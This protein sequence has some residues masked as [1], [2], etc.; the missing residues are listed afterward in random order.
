MQQAVTQHDGKT[1][2][3][4]GLNLQRDELQLTGGT[5]GGR[6]MRRFPTGISESA[7]VFL[8]WVDPLTIGIWPL[9]HG[10]KTA[11]SDPCWQAAMP[12]LSPLLQQRAAWKRARRWSV[13]F[14][15]GHFLQKAADKEQFTDFRMMEKLVKL[16]VL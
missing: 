16:P 3:A 1:A 5:G 4:E 13:Y 10:P 2:P 6:A 9:S 14:L 12:A 8:M 7:W 11:V 15:V